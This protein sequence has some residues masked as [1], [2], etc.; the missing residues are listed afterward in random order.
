MRLLV[1]CKLLWLWMSRY[2]FRLF[3]NVIFARRLLGVWIRR[4]LLYWHC[5]KLLRLLN[6]FV[7]RNLKVG[8]LTR[9]GEWRLLARFCE[10][11]RSSPRIVLMR[12]LVKYRNVVRR[13]VLLIRVYV[14][15]LRMTRLRYRDL[16][17]FCRVLNVMI[18]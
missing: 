14:F 9:V 15:R 13:V 10:V 4:Y 2:V 11:I 1:L 6:W 16:W 17:K 18:P 12:M 8:R 5:V 7:A 3:E